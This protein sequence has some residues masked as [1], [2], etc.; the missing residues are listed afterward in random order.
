V[1]LS[2]ALQWTT[3]F[4]MVCDWRYTIFLIDVLW[5]FHFFTKFWHLHSN[6]INSKINVHNCLCFWL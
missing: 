6:L 1:I 4:T 2:V 5:L 3:K